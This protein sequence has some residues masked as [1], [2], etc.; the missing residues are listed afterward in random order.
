LRRASLYAASESKGES[1][2]QVYTF[3]SIARWAGANEMLSE[4]AN[5]PVADTL[6]ITAILSTDTRKGNVDASGIGPDLAIATGLAL[7]GLTD[8]E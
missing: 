7:R 4:M 3:G 1:I 8:D 5:L 6:P 2:D